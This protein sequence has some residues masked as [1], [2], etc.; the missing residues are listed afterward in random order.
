M[1]AGLVPPG[2]SMAGQ[3]T[4]RTPGGTV[5]RN[6]PIMIYLHPNTETYDASA[7]ASLLVNLGSLEG[8]HDVRRPSRCCDGGMLAAPPATPSW[9]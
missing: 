3:P 8:F 4:P 7:G 5:I 2:A 9:H 1:Q 6:K